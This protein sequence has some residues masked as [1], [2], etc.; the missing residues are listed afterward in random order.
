MQKNDLDCTELVQHALVLESCEA[1]SSSAT[2][3]AMSGKPSDLTIQ[4]V[5]TQGTKSSCLA[6]RATATQ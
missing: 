6:S 1:V 2:F 5:S 4:L 3:C